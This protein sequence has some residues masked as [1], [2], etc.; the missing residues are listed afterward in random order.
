MIYAG[1]SYETSGADDQIGTSAYNISYNDNAYVGYMYGST[2][3]SSYTPTH[4][5]NNNSTIKGVLDGWYE[6]NLQENYAQYLSTEAGFC[7]DRSLN[8]TSET[9]WSPDTKRGYETNATAYGP[10]GRL[11]LNG[12]YRSSQNPSLLCS[13][14]NDMFTVSESSKGNHELTYPIGLITSDEVVLAGGF[15]GSNNSRYYLYTGEDYW[16][17][18]PNSFIAVSIRAVVLRVYSIGSLGTNGSWVDSTN[19]VRPVINLSS[20]V[21]L[22]GSGTSTDPYTVVGA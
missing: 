10:Y 6:E 11:L 9:W 12:S 3:Q 13:Q 18:S 7:N 4:A 16:T 19:G 22:S 15:G 2:G 21:T 5:N 1:T 20:D 8:A 14:T 17:M